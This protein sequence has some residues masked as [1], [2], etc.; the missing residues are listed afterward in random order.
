MHELHFLLTIG[1]TIHLDRLFSEMLPARVAY[2]NYNL[3]L[4]QPC[5]YYHY[6]LFQLQM[7][8]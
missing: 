1:V 2:S 6:Y 3:I 7:G 4:R 5:H 8:F